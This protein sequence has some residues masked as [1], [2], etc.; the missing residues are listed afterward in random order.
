MF[1]ADSRAE[2][3]EANQEQLEAL[4]HDFVA[5]GRNPDELPIVFQCNHRDAATALSMEDLKSALR[6]PRCRHVASV[7]ET[8]QGVLDAIQAL[9]GLLNP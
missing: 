7:A 4:R 1:V 3:A 8:G 5:L 2:R 6:W 9:L